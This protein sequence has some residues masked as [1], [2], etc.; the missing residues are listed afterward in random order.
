IVTLLLDQG[1]DVN[2]TGG[3]YGTALGAAAHSGNLDIVTFL[4]N[5]GADINLTGG[6][7][8]TAL[9]TAAYRGWPMIAKFL[10]DQGANPDLTN[11][12]GLRP[13]DLAEQEG[14]RHTMD[15]LDSKC[16]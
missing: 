9:G 5:R 16:V 8:G 10:L 7:Y 11:D 15:L 13:R 6:K 14:N 1:A 3:D 4:L 12:E 2:I